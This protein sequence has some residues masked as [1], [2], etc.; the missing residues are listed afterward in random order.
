VARSSVQRPALPLF[1]WR[2][3]RGMLAENRLHVI[4]LSREAGMHYGFTAAVVAGTQHVGAEGRLRLA[5]AA[6]RL[7]LGMDGITACG[8][9]ADTLTLLAVVAR[10]QAGG[11]AVARAS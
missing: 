5:A 4:D 11:D 9:P 2:R 6:V 7:G 1:D 10:H 3:L 8:L